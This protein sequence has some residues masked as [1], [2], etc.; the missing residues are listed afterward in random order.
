MIT[1]DRESG[2]ITVDGRTLPLDSDEGFALLSDAWLDAAMRIKQQY[3]FTWFGRP[4]IQFGDDLVR[5]QELVFRVQPDVIIETG[6]AHGG[7]L[8]FFAGLCRLFG[9]GR[10]IG[11]DVEI[12]PHNRAAIEAHPLAPL[13][14]LI[15][16]SS[17]DPEIVATVKA[18]VQPA[19]KVLLMLDSNHTAAHV[20]AELEAY[21]PLVGPGSYVLCMDGGGMELAA[22]SAR[23]AAQNWRTDNPNAAAREFARTHP[24][25]VLE[26]PPFLFNESA[27]A[28]WRTAFR[29]GVLRRVT[30][31]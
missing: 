24:E 27:I 12:R 15:E 3:T 29:G 4:V 11:V 26:Q 23:G 17:V 18:Q 7:S 31:E 28:E 30:P 16:G 9:R 19:E 6:V 1:I 2:T 22:R 5:L 13:V 21:A 20:L 8:I 10:V 14:T 25:F